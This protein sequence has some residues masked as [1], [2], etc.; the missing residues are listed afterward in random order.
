M[1]GPI[2]VWAA[3]VIDCVS[4]TTPTPAKKPMDARVS[5]GTVTAVECEK[6]GRAD[7]IYVVVSSSSVTTGDG[8]GSVQVADAL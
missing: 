2:G 7:G 1:I 4:A 6:C 8:V 5:A 3:L